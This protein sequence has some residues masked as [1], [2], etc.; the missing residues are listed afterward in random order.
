MSIRRDAA[1]IENALQELLTDYKHGYFDPSHKKKIEADIAEL[2]RLKKLYM[3][4]Q[5]AEARASMK[6][7]VVGKNI[8]SLT[9][10]MLMQSL[11]RFFWEQK[12]ES[13]I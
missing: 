2:R 8:I 11:M 7:D 1:R 10:H 13:A 12:V 4:M 6:G 5:T 9:F 3:T